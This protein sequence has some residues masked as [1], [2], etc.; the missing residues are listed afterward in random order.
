MKIGI[1]HARGSYSEGWILYCKEKNI[2]YKIVNAYDTNLIHQ[3]DDCDIFLW[4]HHHANPK[5][6]LMA[7]Q[8]LYSLETLGKVVY[9]NWRTGWHFD[10]KVGQKYLLEGHALPLI[11]SYVFYSKVEAMKWLDTADFPF[12]FKLRGGAGSYNVKLVKTRRKAISLIRRSF[13]KGFRQIDPI[14]DFK[15][16][17]RKYRLGHSSMGELLKAIAHIVIPYQ[18]EKS[19]GRERGYFYAQDFIPNCKDD[20]RV[21]M[22]GDKGYAMKRHVRQGDFRASGGGN[23]DYDGFKIPMEAIE[24]SQ[25][26]ERKLEMQSMA[27]DLLSYRDTYL[28][29]E[30]SYA[31]AID[32]DELD[33]GYFDSELKWHKEVFNPFGWLIEDLIIQFEKKVKF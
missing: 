11:P 26:V 20:I 10:D 25:M 7:R 18:I 17:F 19:K 1:H 14:T 29:A 15:E 21:Q 27:I 22:I 23:I 5:D 33:F 30:V 4:H 3:L 8:V 16:R 32:D 2:P 24:I 6:V 28:I 9:P 12:V 13:G 31:F